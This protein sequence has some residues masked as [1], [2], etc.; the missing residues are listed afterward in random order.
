MGLELS[1]GEHLNVLVDVFREVWRVLK[2]QGAECSTT[3]TAMRPA[4]TNKAAADY[5]ADGSDDRTS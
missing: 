4:P 5:K 1:L 3:A 2:P